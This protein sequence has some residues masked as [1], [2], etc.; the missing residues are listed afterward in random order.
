MRYSPIF[1]GMALGF[2]VRTANT[3]PFAQE[4]FPATGN[5][6]E[7]TFGDRPFRVD[8]DTNG[9]QMTFTRPDGSGDTV[10]YTAVEIRPNVFMV[11]WTEPKSGTHVTHVEDFERGMVYAVSFRRD[12]QSVHAT[13]DFAHFTS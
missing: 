10:Q 2:S 8:F 6:Y 1:V 9:K 5:V 12:G 3:T 13:L 11:Y 7:V 4:A